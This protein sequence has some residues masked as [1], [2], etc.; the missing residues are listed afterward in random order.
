M[1]VRI[2]FIMLISVLA[3]SCMDGDLRSA[4]SELDKAIDERHCYDSA[5]FAEVEAMKVAMSAE[6]DDSMKFEIAANIYR[7]YRYHSVDS[8]KRYVDIQQELAQKT[9]IREHVYLT[10][11]RRITQMFIQDRYDMAR[12]LY[13]ALDTTD[14]T[15]NMRKNCYGAGVTLYR[16][17]PDAADKFRYYAQNYVKCGFDQT[18][19]TRM[20]NELLMKDNRPE[21]AL[22]VLMKF[23]NEN[24][25]SLHGYAAI[26]YGIAEAYSDMGDQLQRKI[27]LARSATYDIKASVKEYVSLLQLSRI[28]I[29]EGDYARA[30]SYIKLATEDALFGKYISNIKDNSAVLLDASEALVV[31]ERKRYWI[32]AASLILA[33]MFIVSLVVFS[34]YLMSRRRRL[35]II[36]SALKDANRMLKDVNRIK[37]SYLLRYML[38]SSAYIRRIEE[39]P[40]MYRKLYKTSGVDALV[41]KLKE[42]SYAEDEY[43]QFYR[44]FDEIFLG[45]FPDFPQKVNELLKE[46]A[47]FSYSAGEQMPTGLRILAVIRLG[48]TDSPKIAQF[49]DCALTT[50]YTY[51]NKM[52]AA[53]ICPREDF[54][55]HVKR[56]G[57]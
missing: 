49:L 54:E 36:N 38:L 35:R 2:I 57:F 39:T 10:Q 15:Y 11:I 5:F 13:E 46:E 53:S 43:R 37:D 44:T 6:S 7:R 9:G 24:E 29:K 48:I 45:L 28:L 30:D 56:I 34:V 33:V 4:Y 27:W 26:A 52:K 25:L 41:S 16:R 8:V 31:S 40:R 14:M 32:M 55:N 23:Y 1:K 21:D 42:P 19:N 50:V 47:R 17:F 18:F 51:R 3:V 12:P 22:K 20:Q